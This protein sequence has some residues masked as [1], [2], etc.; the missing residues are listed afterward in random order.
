MSEVIVAATLA[1]GTG[2]GRG[3]EQGDGM[4]GSRA[5]AQASWRIDDKD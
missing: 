3:E 5:R 1:A 2:Y 4:E